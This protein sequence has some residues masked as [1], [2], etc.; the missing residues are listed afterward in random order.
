MNPTNS[1]NP[2]RLAI[3]GAGEWGKNHVRV[4]CDLLGSDHVVVCDTDPARR[5]AAEQAH[6]GVATCALL[7]DGDVEAAVISTPAPTH[8]AVARE[9]LE[10]GLHVLVEKPIALRAEEA[11]E[12][13]AL[14]ARR[15]R[16][17]MVDHLMVYHPAVR[18][19]RRLIDDGALGRVLHVT[20][21]RSNLG[22]VR[23]EE[24]ALWSLAPHDVSVLLFLLG[25]EPEAVAAHGG[26][27]LQRGIEDV[28]YLTMRFP[29]GAVGHV[30]SS[31]LDPV[32]TRRL[33]VVG[34]RGMAVFDDGAPE[35]LLWY[36]HRIQR[37]DGRYVTERAEPAAVEFNREEP[38]RLVARAFLDS[39]RTGSRP[40]ADGEDGLRVVRV[41][42]RAQA[43]LGRW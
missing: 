17:L 37:V 32:K 36:E 19:L 34:D 9:S 43:A 22:I 31:W 28:C 2:I 16:V 26:A 38:L 39:V 11:E 1:T 40:T 18:E 25:G 15:D 42:E 8:Y 23:S 35:P 6:P 41:L 30:H 33:T 4:F 3:L 7:D 21:Q 10:R 20:S 27:F 13:I 14:A 5:A 24:N 12:L 29:S